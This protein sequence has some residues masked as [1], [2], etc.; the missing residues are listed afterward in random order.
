[1]AACTHSLPVRLLEC[2]DE[3]EEV[4]SKEHVAMIDEALSAQPA[5]S[6]SR[7][8]HSINF[9]PTTDDWLEVIVDLLKQ[10]GLPRAGRS[11]VVRVGLS[12]LQRVLAERSP[13]DIVKFFLNHDV[14]WRLS[15]IQPREADGQR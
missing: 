11:E 1:V 5:S 8:V 4:H 6:R 13:E 2:D 10:A 3:T 9:D 7:R 15:R 12:E 14:E